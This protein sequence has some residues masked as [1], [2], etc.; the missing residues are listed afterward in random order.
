M[1]NDAK[2][3]ELKSTKCTARPK[4]VIVY[5]SAPLESSGGADPNVPATYRVWQLTPAGSDQAPAPLVASAS[6]TVT[7]VAYD[8]IIRQAAILGLEPDQQSGQMLLVEVDSKVRSKDGPISP[9]GRQ[10]AV[11]VDGKDMPDKTPE[12]DEELKKILQPPYAIGMNLISRD[13]YNTL[14]NEYFSQ[15]ELS[16]GLILPMVLIVLGLVLTPQL[17]LAPPGW[18]KDPAML[19]E[20]QFWLRG[21]AW[22]FMCLAMV[23]LSEAMFLIGMERYH[24][25]RL[26]VKLLILGNWQKQQDAKKAK[27]S[28][29][30][31]AGKPPS[32]TT[33]PAAGPGTSLSLNLSPVTLDIHTKHSGPP[34]SPNSV[35]DPDKSGGGDGSKKKQLDFELLDRSKIFGGQ[36]PSGSNK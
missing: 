5:F 32:K 6:V 19:H 21:L 1:P 35:T 7:E 24:K 4:V 9:T 33:P 10:Y 15:S 3:N 29:G 20:L 17:G 36:E 28:S 14:K 22:T 34:D 11:E 12:N 25:F 23:R 2:P 31:S 27:G 8:T 30:S 26:E 18:P 16:L 13:D